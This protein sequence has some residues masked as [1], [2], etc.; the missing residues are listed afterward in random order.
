MADRATRERELRAENRRLHANEVDRAHELCEC[1]IEGKAVSQ[2]NIS[3][4]DAAKG[5]TFAADFN[6]L[7]ERSGFRACCVTLVPSKTVDG[8]V[9][10][11]LC[12]EVTACKV[13]ESMIRGHESTYMGDLPR[14]GTG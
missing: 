8:A 7:V 14:E 2:P 13:V 9:S 10:L 6:R 4:A 12:G 1:A 11:Q 5:M 3:V